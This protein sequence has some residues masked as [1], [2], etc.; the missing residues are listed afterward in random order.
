MRVSIIPDIYVQGNDWQ[1]LENTA[2]LKKT[3]FRK[4][5]SQCQQVLDLGCGTGDFTKDV[6]LPS[7]YPC[8]K[9]VGVDTSPAMVAY[10]RT[11]NGHS[12]IRYEVLDAAAPSVSAF[13]EKNGKF[14]RVYSF[15]CLHWIKDQEAVF[16]NIGRL[17]T[18]DGE[19]L[20]LFTAQFVLYDVWHEMAG[21]ER[22]RDIIG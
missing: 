13:V 17:L 21:M 5:S 16:K 11:N 22:W 9:I 3:A 6:L 20:L 12:D 7:N 1:K 18:D 19:C 15:F 10:S 8:R 14:D 4:P 2:A